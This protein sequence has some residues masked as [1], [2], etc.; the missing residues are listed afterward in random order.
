MFATAPIARGQYILEYVGEVRRSQPNQ[1][2]YAVQVANDLFIDSQLR[3]NEAR[4][5]NHSCAPNS[6]MEKW[7]VGDEFRLVLVATRNIAAGAEI[8]FNYN[9]EPTPANRNI[10]RVLKIK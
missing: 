2:F 9:W 1:G 4:F 5:A 10:V 7:V 3:G 8:C 6:R